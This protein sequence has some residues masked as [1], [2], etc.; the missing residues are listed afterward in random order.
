MNAIVVSVNLGIASDKYATAFNPPHAFDALLNQTQEIIDEGLA[1]TSR[2]AAQ[3]NRIALESWSAG[4]QGVSAVI[5]N[6]G[7]HASQID[8][9][10]LADGLH[11]LFKN[12]IPRKINTNNMDKWVAL[13]E[14]A[15][16]GGILFGV[17]HSSIFPEKFIGTTETAEYILQKTGVPKGPPGPPGPGKMRSLYEA[18]RGDFHVKGFYGQ[19]PKDHIAQIVHM[20]ETLYPYLR[21]RWQKQPAPTP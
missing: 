16:N 12:G 11:T 3:L 21:V 15:E 5:M 14:A 18:H 20:G 7:D 19:D 17:T 4:F 10:L 9:V 2:P 13:A 8:A 6:P 1:K